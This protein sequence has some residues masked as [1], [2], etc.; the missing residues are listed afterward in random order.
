[1]VRVLKKARME[2]GNAIQGNILDV[3][4][5]LSQPF[6]VYKLFC[7]LQTHDHHHMITITMKIFSQDFLANSVFRL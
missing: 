6:N 5:G 3:D 2:D 4:K 7:E 1:M